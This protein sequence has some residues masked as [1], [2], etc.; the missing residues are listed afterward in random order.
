MDNPT[1]LKI[2]VLVTRALNLAEQMEYT[3]ECSYEV[4]RLLQVLVGQIQSGVVGELCAG[5]GVGSSWIASA[6][7]PTT[8]FVTIEENASHAAAVKR[9]V[10][11]HLNIRVILGQWKTLLK[12]WKFSLLF[13]STSSRGFDYIG[14]ISATRKTFAWGFARFCSTARLLVQRTPR[15]HSGS[16]SF[17]TGKRYFS[18]P[19]GMIKGGNYLSISFE[20]IVINHR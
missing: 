14:W 19:S 12:E 18:N 16:A 5:C 10:E 1:D 2:P 6:L 4:G 11:P 8:S 15:I 7:K 9:L 20:W 3:G 17:T 13:A